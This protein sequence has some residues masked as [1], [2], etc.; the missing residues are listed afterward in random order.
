VSNGLWDKLDTFYPH[1]GGVSAAH[2]LNG[3]NPSLYSITF[4]GGWTFNNSF[5]SKGNGVNSY[6]TNTRWN[7][8]LFGTQ[9]DVALSLYVTT[10]TSGSYVD[11]ILDSGTGTFIGVVPWQTGS[12]APGY[13]VNDGFTSLAGRNDSRGYFTMSRKNATTNKL[14]INGSLYNTATI[15]SITPINDSIVLG[16]NKVV[17]FTPSANS[18]RAYGFN[19]YGLGL[20][21][22][23]MTTLST[24]IN[25]FQTSLGRNVY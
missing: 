2:A 12:H 24:I 6:G 16:A 21:D 18:N 22:A 15:N 5:G 19:H 4:N 1:I 9:N 17:G 25:T 10:L 13:A 3:K 23:E 7:P 20:T 11:M 8:L 14:F